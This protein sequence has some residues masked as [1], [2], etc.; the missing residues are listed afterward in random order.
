MKFY[1]YGYKNNKIVILIKKFNYKE[2]SRI[3]IKIKVRNIYFWLLFFF[4][5]VNI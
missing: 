2:V 3:Y 4:I 5:N 1:K